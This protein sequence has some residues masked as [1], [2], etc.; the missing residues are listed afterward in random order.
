MSVLQDMLEYVLDV[1]AYLHKIFLKLF[2]DRKVSITRV[3]RPTHRCVVGR[4]VRFTDLRGAS[5]ESQRTG[6]F[7]AFKHFRPR[8][9]AWPQRPAQRTTDLRHVGARVTD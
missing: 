6:S 8:S 5:M 4:M 7:E 3:Q 1:D 9:E 2:E